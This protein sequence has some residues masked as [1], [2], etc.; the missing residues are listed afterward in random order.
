MASLIITIITI[1]I[2]IV[3]SI[4]KP[5]IKVKGATI[6]FYWNIALLGAVIILAFGLL[7]FD[8]FTSNLV[9]DK[10]MNPIKILVLFLSMTC[11]SIF[12]DEL[13]F[14]STLATYILKR[15]NSSQIRIFITFYILVSVLTM[16]TSN[17]IIILTL[18]PFII[19]FCKKA[20]ISP[21]PYLVGEFMAA[22]TWSMIFIIGNP[23]NIYL[24]SSYDIDFV[25]YFLVMAIPTLLSGLLELSLLLLVFHRR[26]KT[27]IGHYYKEQPKLDK[28]LVITGLVILGICTVLL[29]ISSYIS[30]LEMWYVAL[31]SLVVLVIITLIYSLVK[32][33]APIELGKTFKR[34][35]YE[36]IPFLLSMF[37]IALAMK[38]EGYTSKIAEVFGNTN[39]NVI[40]GYTSLLSANL[41]N[42]IPM[43]VMYTHIIENV[44]GSGLNPAIYST[45]IGSNIGAFITPMG[46]LAGIMWMSILKEHK[47]RFSFLDFMKYGIVIGLPVATVAIFSLLLTVN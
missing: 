44:S 37:V 12:L 33:K 9:S 4:V 46:A 8:N 10:G 13:G 19:S 31:G 43:S 5:S 25:K 6:N 35:P 34:A 21:I 26:L 41:L 20:G 18:T 23:T 36:L 15:T 29:V 2:I 22:N 47:V 38:Y 1:I 17:D 27:K 40:Y 3:T 28:F 14:F 7:P 30:F 24:A 32:H 39:T 45:I 42:N 16:F 11:I